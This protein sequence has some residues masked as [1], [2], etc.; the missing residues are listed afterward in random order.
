MTAML[1]DTFGP[2]YHTSN[3]INDVI[4]LLDI[5]IIKE[6]SKI[7]KELLSQDYSLRDVAA[8]IKAWAL[9]IEEC[10]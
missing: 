7:K 3:E 4:D 9:M 6:H 5:S 10:V 2:F 8:G 1:D